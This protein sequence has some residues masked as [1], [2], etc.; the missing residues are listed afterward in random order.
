MSDGSAK[1]EPTLKFAKGDLIELTTNAIRFQLGVHEVPHPS[2]TMNEAGWQLLNGKPLCG[3][4][5][6][7]VDIRPYDQTWPYFVRLDG[8]KVPIQFQEHHLKLANPLEWLATISRR[9]ASHAQSD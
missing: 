1:I 7:I 5:G 6:R 3:T 2:W 4:R 9:R 8:C